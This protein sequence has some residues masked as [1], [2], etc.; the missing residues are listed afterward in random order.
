[1]FWGEPDFGYWLFVISYL[2]L[3]IGSFQGEFKLRVI[4]YLVDSL[5]FIGHVTILWCSFGSGL[6]FE[7]CWL[8]WLQRLNT[9]VWDWDIERLVNPFGGDLGGC[10]WS[11]V[12]EY[13]ALL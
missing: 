3:I 11:D 7:S 13:F 12:F 5:K 4:R 6:S 9:G 8:R 10:E 1:M 2:M